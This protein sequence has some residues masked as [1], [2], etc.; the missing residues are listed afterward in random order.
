[1]QA[2]LTISNTMTPSYVS[3]TNYQQQARPKRPRV[4]DGRSARLGTGPIGS[5]QFES[6]ETDGPATCL[7]WF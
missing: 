2:T 6:L 1:M 5:C 3:R 7:V 4:K